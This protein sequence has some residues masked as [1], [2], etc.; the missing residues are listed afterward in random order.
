MTASGVFRW[1][2]RARARASVSREPPGPRL[3]L[4]I[5]FADLTATSARLLERAWY[6]DE[7]RCFIPHLVQKSENRED[8]NILAPSDVKISAIPNVEK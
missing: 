8:V 4:T 6:A 1:A 7:I 2:S 5:L 3:S